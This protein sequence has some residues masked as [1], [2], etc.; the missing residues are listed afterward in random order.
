MS[1]NIRV[2]VLYDFGT[3]HVQQK[4]CETFSSYLR[5]GCHLLSV[6]IKYV[7]SSWSTYD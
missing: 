6:I 3:Q 4:I 5:C 7:G 2:I 1:I